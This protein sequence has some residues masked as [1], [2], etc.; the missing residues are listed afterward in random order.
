[1]EERLRGGD[2]KIEVCLLVETLRVPEAEKIAAT[3]ATQFPKAEIGV[4]RL[5]CE[6]M[7]NG[8]P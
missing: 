4:Y 1:M 6:I 2:R 7:A 8:H 5:L 3:L